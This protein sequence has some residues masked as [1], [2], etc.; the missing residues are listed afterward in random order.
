MYDVCKHVVETPSVI[1]TMA[2]QSETVTSILD[3]N[4]KQLDTNHIDSQRDMCMVHSRMHVYV[5]HHVHAV[6]TVNYYTEI[7]VELN[8]H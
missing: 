3:L 7:K 5:Y 1:Y 6:L 8:S 4:D 2:T